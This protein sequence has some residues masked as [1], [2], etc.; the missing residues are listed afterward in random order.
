MIKPIINQTGG[1]RGAAL[2]TVLLLVTVM[3]LGA[4]VTFE[5]LGFSIKRAGALR[6]YDQAR[7]YA[8]GGEQLALSVAETLYE[9]ETVLVEPRAVSFP[10]DGGRIDGV[11]TDNS[12]CF[13]VNSLV[14]RRDIGTF[15]ANAETG[16]QFWRL[17]TA[18]G[19]A[20]R[21]AEE[22]L[23]ALTD[24]LDSDSR[25][26]P[27]GA[28]DYDYA[29]LQDPYRAANGLMADMS[30]LYMVQGFDPVL[31]EVLKPFLCA[32]ATT[33]PS[34]LNLNSLTEQHAP[35]LV[36]LI[37]G[38][39]SFDMATELILARPG[40]GYGN[41][42]DFW[43]DPLLAGRETEQSVRRQTSVKAHQFTSRLRVTYYDAVSYLTTDINV[44]E[45]GV[46][47]VVRHHAGVLP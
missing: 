13:N 28:E 1:E 38:D 17:L 45:S 3:A 24:W 40:N 29:N 27:M 10:I 25:P 33:E 41:V 31:L 19:I 37:G 6:E 47:S 14:S 11:I 23:A 44:D 42:A 20:D 21:Q 2:V 30:E 4:V 8:I 22:L 46:A 5:A 39:F 12:N 9:S 16:R 32:G 26:S 7:Q 34:A 36:A 35:L 15:V 18:L 43:L